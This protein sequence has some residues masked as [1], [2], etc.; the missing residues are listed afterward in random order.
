MGR[1][2]ITWVLFLSAA[3]N[4]GAQI[5]VG[6]WP[7]R[8]ATDLREEQTVSAARLRHK[9]ISKAVSAFSRALKL[10]QSGAWEMGARELEKAV[11]IDPGFSEAHGN[12]G[13]HYF[14]LGRLEQAAHEF[15]CAIELDP[16]TSLDH[17]NLAVTMVL[18]RRPEEAEM[19][20]QTAIG[21]DGA[22]FRAHYVLGILLARRREMR[23]EAAEHLLYAARE[24]PEAHLE[25]AQLFRAAGDERRATLEL[26]RYS[27]AI[28]PQRGK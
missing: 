11:A 22:N 7:F 16:S 2:F 27:L 28:A 19:E 15:R 23:E 26:D 20:A 13:V 1:A 21:L 12:L 10:A 4:C 3:S 8:T 14:K 5:P 6:S 17:S 18:L 9:F 24:V 25:L